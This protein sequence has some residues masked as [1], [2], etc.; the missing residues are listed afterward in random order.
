MYF[1]RIHQNAVSNKNNNQHII[2]IFLEKS[3][4]MTDQIN[5]F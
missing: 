2:I 5:P 1:L 3:I 4:V